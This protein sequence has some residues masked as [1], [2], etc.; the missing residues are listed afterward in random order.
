VLTEIL[1]SLCPGVFDSQNSLLWRVLL[2]MCV[3]VCVYVC[4]CVCE[5]ERESVCVCGVCVC[6]S[7][8][9]CVCVYV[10][11]I[12]AWRYT[13]ESIGPAIATV[14]TAITCV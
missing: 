12:C 9:V 2:R 6:V 3:C 10:C 13:K 14:S 11:N 5:R 1:Q 7:V 8:C 4:V